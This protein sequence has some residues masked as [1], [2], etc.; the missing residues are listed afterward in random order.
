MVEAICAEAFT[1]AL[2]YEGRVVVVG[3]Y[4]GRLYRVVLAPEADNVWYCVTAHQARKPD[5]RRYV[6]EKG[7]W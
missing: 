1:I 6:Q 4:D 7:S 5:E 2:S 3:P